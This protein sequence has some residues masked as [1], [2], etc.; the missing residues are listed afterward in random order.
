MTSDDALGVLERVA[1]ALDGPRD[2]ARL[3]PP[4][5]LTAIVGSRPAPP[6]PPDRLRAPVRK[7]GLPIQTGY[8]QNRD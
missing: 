3:D 4:K 1:A 5:R 8:E 6:R 2:R 7:L